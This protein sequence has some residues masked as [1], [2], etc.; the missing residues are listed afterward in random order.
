MVILKEE[1]KVNCFKCN[2]PFALKYNYPLKKYS[3][4]NN[5]YYWTEKKEY[6][7]KHICDKCLLNFYLKNKKEYWQE[8]TNPKKRETISS[9]IYHL[10][11]SV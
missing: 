5:W 11:K 10:K 4:K 7:G 9:Y 2:K 6:K 8:V 3:D 1:L